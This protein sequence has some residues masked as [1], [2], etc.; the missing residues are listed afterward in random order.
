MLALSAG[1]A[2]VE[3]LVP[4][5][6]LVDV[7]ALVASVELA[8]AGALVLSAEEVDMALAVPPLPAGSLEAGVCPQRS[9]TGAPFL[10]A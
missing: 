9:R 1:L 7:E 8:G 6:E 10:M 2:G 5:V 3:V 4:S